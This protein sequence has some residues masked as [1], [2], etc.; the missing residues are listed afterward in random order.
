MLTILGDRCWG[1]TKGQ[2]SAEGG[3]RGIWLRQHQQHWN[4]INIV[5]N[6]NIVNIVII[7][8]F[9]D[10]NSGDV[11][12]QFSLAAAIPSGIFNLGFNWLIL[13][14]RIIYFFSTSLISDTHLYDICHWYLDLCTDHLW[15]TLSRKLCRNVLIN[16][17]PRLWTASARKRTR[18]WSSLC[19]SIS[20]RT[21]STNITLHKTILL[22]FKWK[23]SI[24]MAWSWLS[25]T[26]AKNIM[27]SPPPCYSTPL[28]IFT[29]ANKS[30]CI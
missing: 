21:L 22:I 8:I 12:E 10:T 24:K 14:H 11:S 1:R 2:Q 30:R 16:S 18:Q 26:S 19:H 17:P 7:D 13:Y 20:S 3:K 4:I 9:N 29:Q 27:L 28:E 15:I 25:T 6:I 5:N 23:P